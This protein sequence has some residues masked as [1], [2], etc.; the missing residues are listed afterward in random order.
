MGE[1]PT[2]RGHRTI[3]S[4]L[5][6]HEKTD[7]EGTMYQR[8]VHLVTKGF[9]QIPG[10][11]YH[12]THSTVAKYPT[13][14]TLLA[15]TAREDMELH[16]IDVVGAYLQGDLN[17]EIYMTPPD[18]LKIKGKTD[19]VLRLKKSLY[20][21]KQ[22]GRQWKKKLDDTMAH[23]KFTKSAADECLYVLHEKGK[24]V[25]LVLIYVDD[26]ATASKDIRQIEWFKHSLQD[27]FPIKDL[28]E[29]RHILGI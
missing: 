5:V 15:L 13:L 4:K 22:A 19:W 20:G 24:V 12:N 2:C 28:G 7:G 1:R 23:L 16:Q 26:A 29:L 11:D 3:G 14:R 6:C 9:S 25:L 10:Q 17:E 18:G 8:K 27:F 21:L